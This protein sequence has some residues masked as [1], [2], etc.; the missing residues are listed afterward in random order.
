VPLKATAL[1]PVKLVPL[2]VTGVPTAPPDGE[3]PVIVGGAA[4]A[5][6]DL[7]ASGADSAVVVRE[8]GS[9]SSATAMTAAAGTNVPPARPTATSMG[10]N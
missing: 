1:A 6:E 9:A 3:K 7:L 8:L 10:I 4:R 5:A 2:I